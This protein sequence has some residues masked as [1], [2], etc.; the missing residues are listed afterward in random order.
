VN[1]REVSAD[2]LP[3][4][5]ARLA[6][7]RYFRESDDAAHPPVAMINRS[8]AAKYFGSEDPIGERLLFAPTTS[9]PPMAIVGIVEDIQEAPLDK[10]GLPTM[11]LPFHQNPSSNFALVVRTAQPDLPI[12]PALMAAI[13]EIDRNISTYSPAKMTQLI[14]NSDAVYIRRTSAWL[15]GIF[16]ATALLLSVTGLYVTGLYGVIAYSVSQRTRE[17]GVRMAL[18]AQRQ[19]IYGLVLKEAA[20]LIA[21]G[22]AAG[23]A[24]SI[25]AV[26]FLRKLLFGVSTWDAPTWVA[27]AAVLVV[28]AV[29]ASYF[30]ARRATRINPV[31]ALKIE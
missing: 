23:I 14:G 21:A 13:R 4:L 11:Y 25:G 22:S 8:F 29:A 31:E 19:M 6:R 30:P 17:I 3:T 16:A 12:L 5:G 18:G 1:Y 2:Y 10:A 20:W 9:D 27:V 28:S 15:T 26:S 24:A 7:G